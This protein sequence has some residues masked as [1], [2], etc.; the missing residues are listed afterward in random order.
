MAL[1]LYQVMRQWLKRAGHQASPEM[2]L[3][4]RAV[5]TQVGPKQSYDTDVN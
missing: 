2:A 5:Q 3:P 4:S 1:I